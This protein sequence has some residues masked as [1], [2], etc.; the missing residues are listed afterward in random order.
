M[1]KNHGSARLNEWTFH[2]KPWDAI[3]FMFANPNIL[4]T[5]LSDSQTG[6]D[7][8]YK[9]DY[10]KENCNEMM[11][12]QDLDEIDECEKIIRAFFRRVSGQN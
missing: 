9:R 2:L 4:R 3:S 12:S 10:T 11:P 7:R 5:V 1:F 6:D 8:L